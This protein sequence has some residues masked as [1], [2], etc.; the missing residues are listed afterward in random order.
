M[1]GSIDKVLQ[2]DGTYKWEVVEHA[3]E[4][5]S[6]AKKKISK[7]RKKKTTP[8]PTSTTTTETED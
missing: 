4:A 2:S 8:A 3:R 1:A 6:T 5:D 7:P